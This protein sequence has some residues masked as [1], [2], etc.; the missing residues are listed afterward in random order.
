MVHKDLWH[1]PYN[2]LH[3]VGLIKKE[4]KLRI[5]KNKMRRIEIVGIM[6]FS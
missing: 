5:I 6:A 2:S 4:I 3:Y 1:N